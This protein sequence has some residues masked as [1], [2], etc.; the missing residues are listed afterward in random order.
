[1]I[2]AFLIAFLVTPMAKVI[3]IKVGAIDMPG[4]ERRI[5]T[6]PIPR[7]GGLSIFA[8][9]VLSTLVFMPMDIKTVGLIL[10]SSLIVVMGIVDD[11]KG[12]SAT[13]KMGGQILA[14]MVLVFF[15]FRIEWLTSPL[16]G[17]IYL[18]WLSI[19]AT[20]FWVVGITN[21][22]NLID[23]LDGL[24]AGISAISSVTMFVVALLNGRDT[25]AMLLLIVA[26]AALGFLPHNFNPAKIFMGDTGSLFL[27]FVLSAISIQGTIKGATAIAIVIPVLAMGLPIFD[28]A[29]AIVRRAKNGMPIMQPDRGHLHHR[30]LDM[31]FTQRQVVLILYAISGILGVV[32]IAVTNASPL[33]SLVLTLSVL[34][35]AFIG[36]KRMGLLNPVG[37]KNINA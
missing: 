28:T 29:I 20:V 24:A 27:G 3:A 22:F 8:A 13:V 19:P 2:F 30:L 31:G 16:D 7:M 32:A 25:A 34:L 4:E 11:I 33:W 15:G 6:R 35:A 37:E 17:M 1:M 21:T 23:G 12:L 18:G 5:H 9:F 36:T 10:A 26:G 14:A